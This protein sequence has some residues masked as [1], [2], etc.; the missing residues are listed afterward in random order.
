MLFEGLSRNIGLRLVDIELNG[1]ADDL[2]KKEYESEKGAMMSVMFKD[3]FYMLRFIEIFGDNIKKTHITLPH[4]LKNQ[5]RNAKNIYDK[6][7][8]F[9]SDYA[10]IKYAINTNQEFS[11]YYRDV[12]TYI[13]LPFC[14]RHSIYSPNMVYILMMD[15][16][17]HMLSVHIGYTV[18]DANRA[19]LRNYTN[20]QTAVLIDEIVWLSPTVKDMMKEEL[21][22]WK[23]LK[24]AHKRIKK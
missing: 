10:S 21:L 5:Y 20:E 6:V 2:F 9:K 11:D 3:S 24:N 15:L 13:I 4:I 7:T 16:Y 19:F 18:K 23:Q 1:G 8:A 17:F 22:I 12:L 14:K